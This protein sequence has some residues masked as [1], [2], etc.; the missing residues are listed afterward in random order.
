LSD[1]IGLCALGFVLVLNGK[2][3]MENDNWKM[4]PTAYANSSSSSLRLRAF[5]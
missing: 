2:Y 3:E 1:P 5:A 4:L